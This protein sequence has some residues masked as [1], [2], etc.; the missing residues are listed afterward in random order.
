MSSFNLISHRSRDLERQ[1]DPV[2]HELTQIE[3]DEEVE[4]SLE[5]ARHYESS[6]D[7]WSTQA[8][9]CEEFL[10]NVMLTKKQADELEKRGQSPLP[11]NVVWPAVEQAVAMLTTNHPSFQVTARE[12]SDV[13]TAKV[14]SD[15]LAWVW[16]QSSGNEKLKAACYDYY[17]KGR[18]CLQAY[19]DPDGDFGKGEVVITDVDPLDVY[20]DPNSKDRLWR[21]AA[22]V[23]II[24]TRTAEQIENLWPTS[25]DIL[26]SEAGSI[27]SESTWSTGLVAQDSQQLRGH[28]QDTYHDK[29]KVIER[30][31]KVKI[32]YI[33]V[34]ELYNDYEGIFLKPEFE[35]YKNTPIAVVSDQNGQQQIVDGEE[36]DQA[37]ELWQEGEQTDDERIRI[38]TLPGE[39][40]PTGE[41]VPERILEIALLK[42]DD[43]IEM[44]Q[45]LTREY[46]Q[47]RIRLV[48]SIGNRK[49]WAGYLPIDQYPVVPLN[50]RHFRTP[51]P[52]SD[53]QF[54]MPIQKHINKIQALMTANLSSSTNVKAFVPRGSVDKDEIEAEFARPGA[55]IIEYDAEYGAP[56][57][58]QPVPISAGAYSQFNTLVQ[59]IERE[60]GI[61]SLMQGDASQAPATH[62]GTIAIEQFGQRRIRSKLDDIEGAM[63]HLCRV[64]IPLIQITY[65]TRKV[66]R[67]VNPNNTIKE[68]VA[69]LMQY[70]SFGAAIG[71]SLDLASGIY[72]GVVVTGSTLPNNRFALL[73]YYIDLKREGIIDAQEVLKKTD[74]VDAEGVTERMSIINQQASQIEQL[75]KQLK[76]IG[77]DLQTREREVYH[78]KMALQ[79]ERGEQQINKATNRMDMASQLYEQRQADE[80][81]NTQR[82]LAGIKKIETVKLRP[83]STV[84]RN[85]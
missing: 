52:M 21:D 80:L 38:V 14:M 76:E 81:R 53:V 18:G 64:I 20:P 59:M 23:L 47:T 17:V 55:A 31:T 11:I 40:L 71:K 2:N 63:N 62:K 68:T 75:N 13:K 9:K 19:I 37:A 39:Q 79:V 42:K 83:T 58:A 43:L 46:P 85:E 5:L 8:T 6:Q 41:E 28:G 48:I 15:V 65:T 67:L 66:I 73:D 25:G 70:D 57:I 35:E 36:Y 4:Y 51:Y 56:V 72:D 27:E 78:A 22:H 32:P 12:D 60:M 24:T 10:H 82:E 7:D 44:G 1:E 30:Y 26:E 29:F 34:S 45:I 84:K 50:N 3:P 54:V 49:Y 74:V 77:G 33:S 16:Q 69:N 61:F